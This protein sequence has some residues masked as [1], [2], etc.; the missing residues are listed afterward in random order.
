[1]IGNKEGELGIGSG[2]VADSTPEG[3]LSE[4]ILKS[5]FIRQ[6]NIKNFQ[7]LETML[8]ERGKGFLYLDEHLKRMCSSAC[9]FGWKS[10][11]EKLLL[12][13]LERCC[14]VMKNTNAEFMR[15]RLLFSPERGAVTEFCQMKFKGWRDRNEVKLTISGQRTFSGNIFLKHKTTDRK[16]YDS[17]FRNCLKDGYD[18]IIF[19]NEKNELT[20]GAVSN[21][22]IMKAGRWYTPPVECGLLPGIWRA[23]TIKMLNAEVKRLYLEDLTDADE[24]LVGNSVR[25]GGTGKLHF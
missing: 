17:S 23:E 11:S 5:E 25:G 12:E 7:L 1:M 6:N 19:F 18:E 22:F 14:E 3:E 21:I 20:E 24:I 10:C 4:C 2:I 13:A 9:R 16:L 15:V 8:W